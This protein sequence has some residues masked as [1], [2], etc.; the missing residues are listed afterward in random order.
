MKLLEFCQE[1]TAT[2][3]A[4]N[5]PS[6]DVICSVPLTQQEDTQN[7]RSSHITSLENVSSRTRLFIVNKHEKQT[8]PNLNFTAL[9]KILKKLT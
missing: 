4:K 1:L 2:P 8:L 6:N 9:E 7:T 3:D 5:P